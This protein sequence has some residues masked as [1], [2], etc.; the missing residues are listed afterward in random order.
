[1]LD[2]S[3]VLPEEQSEEFN[4]TTL[5]FLDRSMPGSP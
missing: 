3:H 5:D 2:A 1:M 4:R